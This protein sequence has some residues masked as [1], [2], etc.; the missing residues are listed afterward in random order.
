MRWV[1]M[2]WLLLIVATSAKASSTTAGN[3]STPTASTI[4]S[5]VTTASTTNM[6]TPSPASSP[7]TTNT[8]TS[9]PSTKSSTS[10]TNTTITTT[11]TASAT[12]PKSSTSVTSSPANSTS[13]STKPSTTNTSS[14]ITTSSPTSNTSTTISSTSAVNGT[15][16]TTETNTTSLPDTTT[17]M[18]VT[19]T[20][21]YNSTGYENVTINI[22][23]P[24]PYEPL[25]IVDLCNETISIVFKDPGEEDDITESSEYSDEE[26]VASSNEDDSTYFPQSPGYTLTYDTEDTIYFQATCDR[27]DTYNNITSC[28]YTNKSVNSWS[29]VTSVSFFPPTLTPCHKPV[30]II[31][32]GNDS[33]V[34]SASATS[35]LV[36]AIYKLLGLPDVNSDFLNQLGRYHPITLQGQIEYRDWYT[37]E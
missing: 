35:N 28:D 3:T 19:T 23:T 14:P 1:A 31:K 18:N 25:Q 26:P 21:P 7:A 22:T 16:S 24:S 27:N 9:S 15:N 33:L 11:G 2:R 5:T 37:T 13:T 36:D 30:A 17:D 12:T 4:T 32:I 29:T 20:E 8:T 34:V 6:S 10:S